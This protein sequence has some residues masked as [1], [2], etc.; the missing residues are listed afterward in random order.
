MAQITLTANVSGAPNSLGAS[1][2]AQF[3]CF[4]DEVVEFTRDVDGTYEPIWNEQW[5][6][7]VAVNNGSVEFIVEVTKGSSYLVFP[8]APGA[9]LV[10]PGSFGVGGALA[11]GTAIN[12]Y[13]ASGSTR[14]LFMIGSANS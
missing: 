14:G 1:M 8:V 13:T 5:T 4:A 2:Q 6:F 7:L 11:T 12:V 9:H 10:L 3:T